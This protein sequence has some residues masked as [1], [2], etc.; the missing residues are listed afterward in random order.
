MDNV[1]LEKVNE[2]IQKNNEK[3]KANE[4]AVNAV[5]D[6]IEK[7]TDRHLSKNSRMEFEKYIA[8]YSL[9]EVLE[10]V[11]ISARTYLKYDD[12]GDLIE[13]SIN[14]FFHRIKG[15]CRNRQEGDTLKEVFYIR[16][17]LRNRLSY[18][19]ENRIT[20]ALIL[21]QE[22]DCDMKHIEREA[23]LMKTWT[24]LRNFLE[25]YAEIDL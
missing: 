19:D 23:K 4:I 18:Y 16:A 13:D 25:E 11:K 7:Y 20:H 5:D 21:A 3:M 1:N 6:A 2:T 14:N 9:E 17:I 12:K 15:I 10:A 24:E 8:D 22:K